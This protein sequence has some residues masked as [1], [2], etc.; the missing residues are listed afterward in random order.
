MNVQPRADQRSTEPSLHPP[1]S[2]LVVTLE[3]VRKSDVSQVGGKGANLGEMIAAGLPVPSGFVVTS[4]AFLRTLEANDLRRELMERFLELRPEAPDFA[5]QSQALRDLV[6]RVK[7][8][9]ALVAQITQA[10]SALGKDP[11][12]AVRSSAT[13]EDTEGTSFAG[14]HSTFTNVRTA[15]QLLERVVD[16][17]VSLYVDRAMVYRKARGLTDEPSIAVVVQRMVNSRRAGVLF[18]VDPSTGDRQ[19][20]IIEGAFGLGEVVVSG[21]VEPDTYSVAKDRMAVENARIGHKTHQL[22]RGADGGDVRVDFSEEEGSRRVL[23]DQEVL[24]LTRLGKQVEEHYAEPQDMEWAD[25]GRGFVLVQ[26]RPITTLRAKTFAK[27]GARGGATKAMEQPARAQRGSELVSGLA[28]SPGTVSGPVRVLHSPK[29]GRSLNDGDILVAVM[30]S[31]DWLP[32]MRRAAALV[33]DAGGLTSH[34]AIVS[35]EL[36]IPCVV[37]TRKATQVLHDGEVVTVDGAR[38]VVRIG[39]EAQAAQPVVA[40]ATPAMVAPVVEPIATRLYV[41]LAVPEEAEKVAAR[42]V[43]G[44]GLLRAEFMLSS[45]LGGRH[46]KQLLAEGKREELIA[47]LSEALLTIARPFGR[48][49]VIYRSYD[50]RTNEFRNLEGGATYEPVEENPMIGYRG[51]FRYVKDPELFQVELEVLARVREQSPNVHLMIPFVRT[52]WELEACLEMV[53]HSPL[54]RSRGSAKGSIVPRT[55]FQWCARKR[56]AGFSSGRSFRARR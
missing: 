54:G 22:L 24:A 40:A 37:G 49:P 6:K 25:E 42:P 7:L 52:L 33:T 13:A 53:D 56:G 26:T 38:G 4:D 45:A 17:W 36:G 34:A 21:Q 47:Q 28:A 2:T 5:Q 35:R 10:Y 14:M 50:F 15:A 18:T 44:V 11:F 29:E 20:M 51:C 9:D 12:V 55:P 43:D 3:A 27:A 48:R 41:N 16:C 31:P 1:G 39:A 30:T 8:P 23:S 19:R 32:V 46:P